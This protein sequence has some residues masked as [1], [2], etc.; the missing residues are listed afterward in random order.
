MNQK[1]TYTC[2]LYFYGTFF[3]IYSSVEQGYLDGHFSANKLC[4]K[5]IEEDIVLLNVEMHTSIVVQLKLGQSSTVTDQL[6][7]IGDN[8]MFANIIVSK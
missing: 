5:K 4:E 2:I 3:Q 7:V 6:G 8:T 1:K